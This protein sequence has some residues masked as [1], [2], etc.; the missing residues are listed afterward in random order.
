MSRAAPTFGAARGP[1]MTTRLQ[2]LRAASKGTI[3]LAVGVTMLMLAP[4]PAGAAPATTPLITT[5]TGGSTVAGDVPLSATS[6][7]G[8]V[9][10]YVDAAPIGSPVTVVSGTATSDWLSWGAANGSHTFSRGGRDRYTSSSNG[11]AASGWTTN[12]F[13]AASRSSA[14]SSW[15]RRAMARSRRA[16]SVASSS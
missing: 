16:N 8:L 4:M 7:A 14:V 5:P 2:S 15:G 12:R 3:A 10:F 1:D 11:L 6:T 13:D 9:Q